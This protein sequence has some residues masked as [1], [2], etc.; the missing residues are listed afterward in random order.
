MERTRKF[1]NNV[2]LNHIQKYTRKNDSVLDVGCGRGGDM[3]KW[4]P[5]TKKVVMCDPDGDLLSIAKERARKSNVKCICFLHGDV[6]VS[7]K[8]FYDVICYNFSL[9][10]I[11]ETSGKFYRTLKEIK[12]RTK[13]GSRFIGCIPDSEYIMMTGSFRDALG[14]VVNVRDVKGEFGDFISV[15]LVDTPYYGG[16][17]IGEPIAYKDLLITWLEKNGFELVEWSPFTCQ[18]TN[19]I[20]D[21]YSKFCFVRVR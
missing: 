15:M 3:F 12:N 8:S 6:C 14:N 4:M 5:I 1:H 13:L 7:P 10:Y 16:N 11:F 17:F 18:H 9:Q 21:M 20:S 19:T 2:K